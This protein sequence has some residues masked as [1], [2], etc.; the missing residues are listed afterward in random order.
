MSKSDEDEIIVNVGIAA[1]TAWYILSKRRRRR[2]NRKIWIRQWIRTRAT[3][4]A[5][6]NLMLQLRCTDNPSFTNFVRMDTATFDELLQL[7][8][9]LIQ[10]QDTHFRKAIPPGE[11]LAVTLRFLASGKLKYNILYI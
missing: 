5:Y 1:A 9:P 8:A 6:N 2:R 10:R 11:R 4:G 7:V 3:F